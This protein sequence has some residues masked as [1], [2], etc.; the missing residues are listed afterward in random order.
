MTEVIPPVV[1]SRSRL[2]DGSGL[3]PALQARLSETEALLDSVFGAATEAILIAGPDYRVTMVNAAA[4]RAFDF[5]ADQLAGMRIDELLPD[6]PGAW[7]GREGVSGATF[8]LK[9]DGSTFPVEAT[10]TRAAVGGRTFYTAIVRDVTDKRLLQ[11]QYLHAQRMESVGTL[12]GGVA[13]DFNNILTVVLGA[14]DL[15]LARTDLPE[16]V[17]ELV[18]GLLRAGERG[19]RLV[20]QLLTFSR[21][22]VI[23]PRVMDL[24]QLVAETDRM[25]RRVLGEHIEVTTTVARESCR[26]FADPA[27]VEQ[28]VLNLAVNA[29]DA[30]PDG[31]RLAIETRLVEVDA[32]RRPGVKPGVYVRLAV[33]DS[34]HGMDEETRRRVFEPFFTTKEAGKGTGLGLAAVHG[35]AE[36]GGGWVDVAS[37]PGVGTTF[38]VYLPRVTQPAGG[39]SGVTVVRVPRGT[40][41]VLL[42]E[43]EQ[44][45]RWLARVALAANGY[46]VLEAGSGEEAL[47]VAAAHAGRIH[48][49]VTDVVMPRLGGRGLADRLTADR[50]DT[51]V[52][53]LSGYSG[54]AAVRSGVAFLQKPFTP[55]VLAR[56][57][58]QVLDAAGAN[59]RL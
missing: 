38:R 52:L 28:V 24:N 55:A 58:R 57:V 37:A 19:A 29:R 12:A 18:A 56:K 36:Q 47:A 46:T 54:E 27:Q 41:T 33:A 50:P 22:Q 42:V 10:V 26:V 44:D 23:E 59:Q 8:G 6:E 3:K 32:R 20:R 11:A 34:G 53:Y 13:H 49:L 21:K 5:T 31:G 16:D 48:L 40:E 45:V 14:G 2:D 43:D 9:R 15:L 35:I 25:L 30:M 4:E 1:G 17:R 39:E 7:A 51:R